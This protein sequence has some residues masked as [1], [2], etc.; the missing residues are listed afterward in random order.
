MS[1]RKLATIRRIAEV[2]AIEG[3]DK[4]VAYRVDVWFVVD[5]KDKYQVNDL[6][7]YCE[8]DSWIPH[9]IAPFLT[10]P[11]QFPKV[12]K[13]VEGQKLRT[14]R[15]KGQLSQG[16]LLPINVL[17]IQTNSGSYLGQ[18]DGFEGH[19][20][21]ERL[22]IQKW[23]ADIPAQLQGQMKGS[24]P[25]FIRK[26][27]QERIQNMHNLQQYQDTLFEV[28]EKLEGSSISIFFNNGEF[29]VCSRNVEL[30]DDG[31][32]T[33]WRVTKQYGLEEK[34]RSLGRNIAIQ[35]ELIGPNI[36][37]NIYKLQAPDFYVFDMFD[38][39]KQEYLSASERI[40]L[41]VG[42]LSLKHTPVIGH[43]KGLDS[44]QAYLDLSEGK[45]V[46]NPNQE[47]EGL[48]FKALDGSFSFK[49]ISNRYLLKQKD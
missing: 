49:V 41:S 30:K 22:G 44:T 6:V 40:E 1:E 20:V 13:G 24:F 21:T 42:T 27:D 46:L 45:S 38:I 28:T 9:S 14:I 18:W 15:L 3:A 16:L 47:R 39:D 43:L 10:K 26:T 34:L 37:G 17:A 35:G 5:S 11:D 12:Y 32:N 29:G 31:A 48:V 23:E 33:F 36:Q 4:I 19:D 25:S 7:V 8:P 2:K